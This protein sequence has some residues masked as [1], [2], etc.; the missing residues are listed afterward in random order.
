MSVRT[1]AYK[2]RV[3]SETYVKTPD[4]AFWPSFWAQYATSGELL[5]GEKLLGEKLV[6]RAG[7][8]PATVGLEPT[9]LSVKLTEHFGEIYVGEIV[10]IMA[11]HIPEILKNVKR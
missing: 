5:L 7:I 9:A 4:I 11:I 8:E 6:P 2:R 10:L 3:G 1:I